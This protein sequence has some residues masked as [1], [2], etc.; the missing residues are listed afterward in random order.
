MLEKQAIRRGTRRRKRVGTAMAS[1]MGRWVEVGL[2]GL[3]GVAHWSE[4]EG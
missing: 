3:G 4:G 2:D 1:M